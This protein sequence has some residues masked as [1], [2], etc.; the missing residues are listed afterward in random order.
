MADAERRSRSSWATTWSN[1]NAGVSWNRYVATRRRSIRVSDHRQVR[2]EHSDGRKHSESGDRYL[3]WMAVVE[4]AVDDT[5][6]DGVIRR[7]EHD[8]MV[9]PT[10]IREP[11]ELF[12]AVQRS[13][14][15]LDLLESEIATAS[16]PAFDSLQAHGDAAR[17][18]TEAVDAYRAWSEPSLL[19]GVDAARP[20][21]E[22]AAIADSIYGH[23]RARLEAAPVESAWRIGLLRVRRR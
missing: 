14:L 19:A 17:Y 13:G 21:H 4:S 16:D 8:A 5:L 15:P 18:A 20:P 1:P 3:D 10:Y 23:T 6:A 22:R 9:I 7:D 12:G 2:T 11:D